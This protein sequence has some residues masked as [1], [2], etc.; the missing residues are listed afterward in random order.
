[1]NRASSPTGWVRNPIMKSPELDPGQASSYEL[2]WTF[3]PISGCLNWCPYCYARRLANTRLRDRYLANK[4]VAG[5]DTYHP[6]RQESALND[7]FYPR[8]WEDKLF[9][10]MRQRKT[11]KGIFTCDMS[12][13]FGIGVPDLWTAHVI[14]TIRCCPQHRFYLLTK[15]SQ[16]LAKFSPFPEN[17]WV[18]AT[19][20][21]FDGC[22]KTLANLEKIEA[23][24]KYLSI[25]PYLSQIPD[26][27]NLAITKTVDWIIIGACTG[28]LSELKPLL[29]QY[30]DLFPM[31]L[32]KL[33]GGRWTL[34]PKIEWVQEIVEAAD[35]AGVKVFL[36]DNLSS[37]FVRDSKE[38]E[39]HTFQETFAWA[40]NSESRL[41]QEMP[42]E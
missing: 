9:E 37:V 41:R 10:P 5:Y 3:N 29:L 21:S 24:V 13:L 36:K 31:P 1:M 35:K 23:S 40:L 4:N 28:M 7:P 15:Q 33:D 16:N 34:Q 17:A 25:E 38:A 11:A 6:R 22:T 26:W 20:T 27:A 39:L 2:G 8:F 19:I 30:P 14:T 12:D 32:G 18:G 42:H